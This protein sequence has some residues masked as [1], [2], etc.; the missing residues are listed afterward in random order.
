MAVFYLALYSA[1][2][3]T[4]LLFCSDSHFS[5]L[6]WWSFVDEKGKK[7]ERLS[8][9]IQDYSS[10]LFSRQY[11]FSSE[12][13]LSTIIFYNILLR[14]EGVRTNHLKWFIKTQEIDNLNMPPLLLNRQKYDF[15]RYGSHVI[16]NSYFFPIY[17]F[18]MVHVLC[19][20]WT[21]I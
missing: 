21:P 2:L 10:Q 12:F 11:S 7:L 4:S 18:E 3:P 19:R 6:F 14:H 13:V 16:Q 8:P 5:L 15:E 1:K 9:I 20:T 17:F